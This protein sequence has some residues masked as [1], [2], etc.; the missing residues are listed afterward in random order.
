MDRPPH[1]PISDYDPPGMSPERAVAAWW[2]QLDLKTRL[3]IAQGI[4]PGVWHKYD[5]DCCWEELSAIG[6][7]MRLHMRFDEIVREKLAWLNPH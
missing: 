3:N 1:S 2:D 5:W 6:Q 7:Q 4:C